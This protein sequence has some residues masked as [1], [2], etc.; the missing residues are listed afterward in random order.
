M[1]QG[2]V[3]YVSQQAWIQNVTLR[4][5]ILFSRAFDSA[6]YEH[7]IDSC[8]LRTDLEILPAGDLTEIGE[9]VRNCLFTLFKFKININVFVFFFGGRAAFFLSF[10][11]FSSFQDNCNFSIEKF[12]ISKFTSCT[13]NK[14]SSLVLANPHSTS[15]RMNNSTRARLG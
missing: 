12:F 3:A 14:V 6:R 7:V 11:F 4:D 9:R 10:F 2:S 13:L 1:L 5:N 8:A 15:V